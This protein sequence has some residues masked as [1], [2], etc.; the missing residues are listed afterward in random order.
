MINL[1]FTNQI[2]TQ[3]DI[4]VKITYEKTKKTLICVTKKERPTTKSESLQM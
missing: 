1:H 4:R 2:Q 3:F